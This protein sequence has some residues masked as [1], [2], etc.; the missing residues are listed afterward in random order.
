MKKYSI[1]DIAEL[2]NVSVATVSRVINNNGRFSEETRKKVLKVIEET[3]YKTNFSAKSL[4]MNKSFTIGIIVPDISNYF[5]ADVVQ[6]IEEILFSKGYSTIIC[7]TSRSE[8][9]EK[10]Y[11]E[12]LQS[13]GVDGL[14]VISGAKK[15]AF[16]YFNSDKKIPYICIDREPENKKLTT[17]ISSNHY[18]G[19]FEVTETLIQAGARHSIIIMYDRISTSSAERLKG[20]TDAFKKNNIVFEANRSVLVLKNNQSEVSEQIK[21]FLL[22]NDWVDGIFAINDH[23]ALDALTAIKLLNKKSPE[24]IKI[25]GFDN[26]PASNYSHPT[27]SSVKQNTSKIAQAAVDNLLNL[28]DHPKDVANTVLIPVE[29]VLRESSMT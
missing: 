7:N 13:K 14:I 10:A 16:Q 25:I 29:L 24:D 5:F 17:F 12:I 15:F 21:N 20:F 26:I 23:V 8:T 4:R 6:K 19:A 1:K 28:I 2:S 9:K 11:L 27:L 22:D 18:Q 3:G